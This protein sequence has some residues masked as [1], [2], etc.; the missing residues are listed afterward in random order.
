MTP[1]MWI[2]LAEAVMTAEPQIVAA[3]KALIA[4]IKT[5]GAPTAEHE[6][7]AVALHE[8][9]VPKVAA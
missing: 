7:I 2:Q 3:I 8:V 9:A 1:L 4:L 6:A 5:A